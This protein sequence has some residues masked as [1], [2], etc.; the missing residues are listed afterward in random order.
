MKINIISHFTNYKYFLISILIACYVHNT[1]AQNLVFTATNSPNDGYYVIVAKKDNNKFMLTN[2]INL[3]TNTMSSYSPMWTENDTTILDPPTNTSIWRIETRENCGS[4]CILLQN[5]FSGQHLNFANNYPSFSF[6]S[7]DS[8]HNLVPYFLIPSTN[9]ANCFYIA[10]GFNTY[11]KLDNNG[12]FYLSSEPQDLYL[13]RTVAP[14]LANILATANEADSTRYNLIWDEVFDNNNNIIDNY[15]CLIEYGISGFIKGCGKQVMVQHTSGQSN[16]YTIEGLIPNSAYDVY[17]KYIF[18]NNESLWSTKRSF[19]THYSSTCELMLDIEHRTSQ[20]GNGTIKIYNNLETIPRNIL[21]LTD[22]DS[23]TIRIN[24]APGFTRFVYEPGNIPATRLNFSILEASGA[25]TTLFMTETIIPSG[26]FL[27]YTCGNP[28]LNIKPEIL[29][30]NYIC[31]GSTTTLQATTNID[32]ASDTYL[33]TGGATTKSINVTNN[34]TY[35]VTI[36]STNC[37]TMVAAI[38]IASIQSPTITFDESNFS[39]CKGTQTELALNAH[40]SNSTRFSWHDGNSTN[41]QRNITVPPTST[42]F[43]IK[44]YNETPILQTITP[45]SPI[46]VGD[47]ITTDNIVVPFSQW[48]LAK[49]KH[50]YNALAVI[51]QVNIMDDIIIALYLQTSESRI[52]GPNIAVTTLTNVPDI[53]YSQGQN[54]TNAIST[55]CTNN[56]LDINNFVAG[57]ATSLGADW[58]IPSNR[59][60]RDLR[61]DFPKVRNNYKILNG[62]DILQTGVKYWTSV[63]ASETEAAA[64]DSALIFNTIDNDSIVKYPKSTLFKAFALK[65]FSPTSLSLYIGSSNCIAENTI[66]IRII[67]TLEIT[68]LSPIATTTQTTAQGSPIEPIIYKVKHLISHSETSL[69]TGVTVRQNGE[70]LIIEGIPT[71]T[72]IYYYTINLIGENNC[73]NNTISGQITVKAPKQAAGVLIQRN[74]AIHS[75]QSTSMKTGGSIRCVKNR[76]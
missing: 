29:S 44:A 1:N 39:I 57:W 3:N 62:E 23:V 73:G 40:L 20:C 55:F 17:I 67:D 11:L 18:N 69:P 26:E 38:E 4:N 58:F 54:N 50:N 46:K 61:Y 35:G 33:W 27:T 41:T 75:N 66:N 5:Y 37:N 72:G 59:D 65:I 15:I 16:N 21:Y 14:S 30:S 70:D 53:D 47:I 9:T 25:M 10:T 63:E 60:L 64:A 8:T 24:I 51:T 28:C 34:G 45:T 6:Q 76:E 13:Y 12:T 43:A 36:T 74:S 68:L 42:N 7:P 19:T 31:S 52:W 48:T 56:S 71:Q 32:R 22:M 49:Q 2:S